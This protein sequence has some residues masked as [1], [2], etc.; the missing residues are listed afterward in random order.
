VLLGLEE[1]GARF[2]Y[3]GSTGA[4]YGTGRLQ[5]LQGL[6]EGFRRIRLE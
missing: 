2:G 3:A 1:F 5:T 4:T 6:V